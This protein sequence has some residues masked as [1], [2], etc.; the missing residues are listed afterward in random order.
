MSLR[1]VGAGWPRTGT[2]SLKIALETLL[3]S[4]CY[5]MYDLFA[6]PR[7][8]EVWEQALDGDMSGV[9]AVLSGYGAALDWP[10]SFFWRE[11][12]DANPDAVVLL[13]VRDPLDWWESMSATIVPVSEDGR[14]LIG[15]TGR[16]RPMM[17]TLMRQA[18]GADDWSYQGAVL[19]AYERNTAEVRA[20]C[21]AGRLVEWSPGDG[22][23]P[24]CAALEMPEP[25]RPFPWVNTSVQFNERMTH[26]FGPS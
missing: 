19:A 10:A 17:T 1:V 12:L 9:H 2:T 21:P 4:R 20:E 18:T 22:W 11:L 24:I 25:D 13:S 16:Y 5:H 15:D 6:E 14:E 7:Q 3:S 23:G 26:V 8:I